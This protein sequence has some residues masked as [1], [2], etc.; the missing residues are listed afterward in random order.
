MI[1]TVALDEVLA[2]KKI[3]FLKMD[4]EGAEYDALLGAEKLIKECR[5]RMAI[6]IYHK[7][8]DIITIPDLILKMN[9][10]YRITFRHYGLDDLETIM[11]V[12]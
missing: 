11:Y 3:T 9:P 5:P 1:E 7:P 6:S 8:E 10:D 12:E 4:V 2:G